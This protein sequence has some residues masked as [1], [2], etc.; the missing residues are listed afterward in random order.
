MFG[1]SCLESLFLHSIVKKH[2]QQNRNLKKG[3]PKKYDFT[4]K[5]I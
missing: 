5:I 3:K 2:I 1:S 4:F